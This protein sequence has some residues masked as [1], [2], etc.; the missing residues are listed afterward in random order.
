[1]IRFITSC[2][3]GIAGDWKNLLTVAEAE[4]FDAVY[5]DKMKGVEYKFTWDQ[6]TAL[7]KAV[8]TF[9]D[10]NMENILLI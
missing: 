8:Y 5:E 2:F 3:S 6:K 9:H 7:L 4:L 10:R 1:M